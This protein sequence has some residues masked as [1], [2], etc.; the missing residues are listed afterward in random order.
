MVKKAIIPAA[1]YGTRSLPVTKVI[2]KEMFPIGAKPAIQYIVEEA[3]ASGIEELLMIV[4]RAKNLIVDYF[5]RSLELEAFLE[6]QN[7]AHLLKDEFIP[8]GRLYYTRQPYARG[9]GDAIRLGKSFV[10]SE[11][12]A[13]LLPDD[14]VL[15]NGVPAIRQ[16]IEHY[17]RSGKS[18]VG[19]NRVKPEEL[20][21]YGVIRGKPLADGTYRIDDMVEKPKADPPSDL[22]VIGRYVFTPAIFSHL[23]ALPSSGE[24]E[25]QLTEAIRRLA[26]KEGCEGKIIAGE[27]FDIGTSDGYIALLSAVW[28]E[29]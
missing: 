18:V 21:K 4:S 26:A 7:K 16:L 6:R 14:I 3:F 23:E 12:F 28:K 25:I 11:P 27:R 2:P 20:H 15:P 19:L 8:P 9:L 1:G 13:V 5:D 17:E 29:K 10:G 22:A 24:E